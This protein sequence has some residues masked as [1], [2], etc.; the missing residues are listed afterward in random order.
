MNIEEHRR[1][2][3]RKAEIRAIVD[4]LL[5]EY[6]MLEEKIL[7]AVNGIKETDN[8][9]VLEFCPDGKTIKWNKGCIILGKKPYRFIKALYFAQGRRLSIEKIAKAVWN[10][11]G[12]KN[13]TIVVMYHRLAMT[14]AA[15]YFPYE[16]QQ[17]KSGIRVV[18]CENLE[19]KTKPKKVFQPEIVGFELGITK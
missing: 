8:A 3:E 15:A 6:K 13:H 12:T 9:V 11:E 10:E 1:I 7:A 18:E 19:K 4:P 5:A 17:I 16:I 14:L 2:L